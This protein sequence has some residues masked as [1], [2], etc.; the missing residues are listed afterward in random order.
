MNPSMIDFL[1]KKGVR[2]GFFLEYIPTKH[3]ITESL[4]LT[5]EER[6]A[7]RNQILNYR[8]NKKIY[9]IHSPFRSC[10]SIWSFNTLPS[11]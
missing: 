9:L 3:D 7:F 10:Y 6:T 11:F 5:E 1:I 8:A 4:M 2:I